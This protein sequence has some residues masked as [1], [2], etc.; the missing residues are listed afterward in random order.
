MKIIGIVGSRRRTSDKDLELLLHKFVD[1][2]EEGD[3]IVSGGCP[4][5]ADKWAEAIAAQYDLTEEN[6]KLIVHRPESVP[7]GSSYYKY[8]QAFHNRNTLIAEEC[9]VLIAVVARDR[10]GGTEDT[11]KK[12]TNFGRKLIF[13]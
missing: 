8:V 5:G 6:G 10:T 3:K 13:T 1:I 2:Y 4:E 9:D 12:A 11:V 7:R